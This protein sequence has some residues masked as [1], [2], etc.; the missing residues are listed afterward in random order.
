MCAIHLMTFTYQKLKMFLLQMKKLANHSYPMSSW[1]WQKTFLSKE[2]NEKETKHEGIGVELT[3]K[4]KCSYK[5]VRGACNPCKCKIPN[6][7][8]KLLRTII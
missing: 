2:N 8:K 1:P 7:K 4:T 5:W 3:S 6:F